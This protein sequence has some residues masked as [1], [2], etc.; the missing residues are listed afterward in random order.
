M[1]T[2]H[3]IVDS[4]LGAITLAARDG[5][6]SRLSFADEKRPPRTASLG[7]RVNTGF[8][9]VAEQLSEYFAG[10]RTVF[11]VDLAPQ[12]DGFQQRV[13][14]LLKEIPYGET[15]SYGQLAVALGDPSLARA[16][17][18]ANGQ[19][20][21]GIIVPC[22]RVIGADG[23]LVGYAG[24][25]HRKQSLLDLEESVARGGRLF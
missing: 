5:L 17:G 2:T 3:T 9:S 16:V 6:L 7:D 11:D 13:W 18:A 10:G 14:A 15:R 21:V 20:P 8:E 1:T 19:N 22:H 12:G 23:K 4:P 25:L 24:G